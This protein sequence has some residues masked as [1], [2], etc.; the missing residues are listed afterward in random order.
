[1]TMEGCLW[2]IVI[3]DR[4]LRLRQLLL[5]STFHKPHFIGLRAAI[6]YWT[7]AV[8]TTVQTTAGPGAAL[9]VVLV[10]DKDW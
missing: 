4:W 8:Q 7:S 2:R 6:R 9:A 5:G 10:V 3:A 1:M